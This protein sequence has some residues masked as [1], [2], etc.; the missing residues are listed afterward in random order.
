MVELE[1]LFETGLNLT[2]S[3][4]ISDQSFKKNHIYSDSFM[5]LIARK[6]KSIHTSTNRSIKM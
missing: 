2:F 6:P 1:K 3:Y 5:K 4:L